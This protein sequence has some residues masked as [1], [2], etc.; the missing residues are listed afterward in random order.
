MFQKKRI[1]M[2]GTAEKRNNFDGR[3]RNWDAK[4]SRV[5]LAAAVADA[6]LRSLELT[7]EMTVMDYGA[8]TGLVTMHIAP[9]VGRIDAVDTS[10]GMLAILSEK[11]RNLKTDSVKVV[12]LPEVELILPSGRYNA[13]I[14]SM[15][16]HHISDVAGI[17]GKFYDALHPGGQIAIADLVEENGDFHSD[18]TG[19]KHFGFNTKEFAGI[20]REAGFINVEV[21][22][23]HTVIKETALGEIKDFPVFLLTGM[24]S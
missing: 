23:A 8:G 4:Q 6:M 14:S 17:A 21:I 5:E 12:F 7:R 10:E 15:T 2:S 11:V 24:K 13:I 19:V 3:A 9:H 18:N 22:T 1:M 20:F 16:I